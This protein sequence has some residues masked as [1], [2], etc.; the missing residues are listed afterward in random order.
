M[1]TP[2]FTSMLHFCNHSRGETAMP[3]IALLGLLLAAFPV[4]AADPPA[5]VVALS[6]QKR[7]DVQ[8]VKKL[9]KPDG[10]IVDE[11]TTEARPVAMTQNF[12]PT[13]SAVVICDMWD[14]HWCASAAKRCDGLAKTTAPLIEEL[15][16]AGVT[17]IHA[18][19]DC[20]DYYK[21]HPARVRTLAVKAT[22]PP[23]NKQLADPPLPIDDSDG[24]C[25]DGKTPFRK[26]W[27]KQHEAIKIDG[28]KDYITDSGKVVY[29]ILADRGIKTVFVLGVHTNMCVL[30]RTFAIK[31]LRKWDVDCLLVRDLTD[32]MYNPKMKPFVTHEAGTN[33]VIEFIERH[34]CPTT[35]SAMLLNALG[36]KK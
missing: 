22:E 15:R 12:D 2:L 6:V 29:S 7:N 5:R 35:T 9:T 24:G 34:W 21:D 19:S 3:R 33:L 36:V 14:D 11:I 23:K 25:D 18:P 28:D 32:A 30:H 31:Q 16:K 1:R 4:V 17:I 27:S 10:T 20:M 13:K 26:A 8:I